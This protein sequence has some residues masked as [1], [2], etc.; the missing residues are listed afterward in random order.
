MFFRLCLVASLNLVGLSSPMD[1]FQGSGD[2]EF[3]LVK[4]LDQFA[5]N[6][7]EHYLSLLD[8]YKDIVPEEYH[9]I[10]DGLGQLINNTYHEEPWIL[11]YFYSTLRDL[12]LHISEKALDNMAGAYDELTSGRRSI[13][14]TLLGI[15]R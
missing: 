12:S 4:L 11:E 5:Q 3:P 2:G 14:S 6:D 15:T 10:L 7:V 1:T 9:G 8:D 13:P